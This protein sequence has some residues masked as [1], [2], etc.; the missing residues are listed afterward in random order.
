MP[1]RKEMQPYTRASIMATMPGQIGVYG[2][3]KG[4]VAV[5]IGSGDIRER[6]LAHIGGD[7]PC[8]NNLKPD[9]W[10]A[11]VITASDLVAR[12]LAYVREYKPLC[13]RIILK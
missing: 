10:V 7:N 12:E 4:S 1:F 9:H 5:Y 2:I 13:N 8:I 6:L 3:F 11:E